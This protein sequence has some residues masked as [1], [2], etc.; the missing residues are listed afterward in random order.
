MNIRSK[1]LVVLLFLSISGN[2]YLIYQI[3]QSQRTAYFESSLNSYIELGSYGV[4]SIS[5]G[6]NTGRNDPCLPGVEIKAG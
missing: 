2:I 6:W 1:I 3:Q 5:H 4:I